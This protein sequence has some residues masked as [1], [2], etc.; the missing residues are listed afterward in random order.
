[1]DLY[2]YKSNLGMMEPVAMIDQYVKLLYSN[3]WR[4]LKVTYLEGIPPFQFLDIGAVAAQTVSNKTQATNLEMFD[5]EFG[6]FRF[7]PL[8]EFQARLWLPQADGRYRLKNTMSIVDQM[9]PLRD[10]D[11]H[12]TEF[13]V[14][15]DN[16]PYLEAINL[17]DYAQN[18]CRFVGMGFRYKTE[19]VSANVQA[20]IQSGSQACVRVVCQGM[21]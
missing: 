18:Q 10:P 15:Q 6:Q 14:W 4:Y 20:Q 13:F 8:D 19:P 7:Y 1:M 2:P 21:S 3:K 9:T 16:S 17:T 5:D 11:L 12:F